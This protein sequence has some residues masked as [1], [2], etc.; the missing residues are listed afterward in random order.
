VKKEDP[1]TVLPLSQSRHEIV[2]RGTP[3]G[4][5]QS[6]IE[7][8]RGE[9]QT[10]IPVQQAGILESPERLPTPPAQLSQ[11]ENSIDVTNDQ[12]QPAEWRVEIDYSMAPHLETFGDLLLR[13]SELSL[14]GLQVPS[15]DDGFELADD[16]IPLPFLDQLEVEMSCTAA[17]YALYFTRYPPGRCDS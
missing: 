15:P 10:P 8:D 5:H 12:L 14:D 17:A 3:F 9:V 2:V 11:K 13:L 16:F 4:G 7:G 1:K 6:N